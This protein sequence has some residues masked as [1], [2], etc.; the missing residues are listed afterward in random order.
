M[1]LC[2]MFPLQARIHET[3]ASRVFLFERFDLVE[4]VLTPG[5]ARVQ[6]ENGAGGVCHVGSLGQLN[7]ARSPVVKPVST[8]RISSCSTFRFG[9]F[10]H[11]L[12]LRIVRFLLTRKNRLKLSPNMGGDS[13]CWL[14][15]ESVRR[16]ARQGDDQKTQARRHWGITSNAIGGG[17][18]HVFSMKVAFGGRVDRCR[19][20]SDGSAAADW[21]LRRENIGNCW[22]RGVPAATKKGV[23]GQT[24][25]VGFTATCR[26]TA[27]PPPMNAFG[28]FYT[29]FSPI[30]ITIGRSTRQRDGLGRQNAAARSAV[31]RVRNTLCGRTERGRPLAKRVC[32]LAAKFDE[33]VERQF[34]PE[35][36]FLR[37][38]DIRNEAYCGHQYCSESGSVAV[39]RASRS[40]RWLLSQRG[41]RSISRI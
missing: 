23:R 39:S 12:A 25:I 16:T 13:G 1:L 14:I 31:P 41:S 32:A 3:C 6:S 2:S 15:A 21:L 5:R 8:S 10:R 4:T 40:C 11:F 17:L 29:G 34:H 35:W 18:G 37:M 36:G 33:L 27:A 19:P 28:R 9:L 20:R 30:R 38:W 24:L 22:V 26:P 7:T